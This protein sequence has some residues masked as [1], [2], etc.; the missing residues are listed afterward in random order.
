MDKKNCTLFA[1][2]SHAFDINDVFITDHLL[3]LIQDIISPTGTCIRADNRDIINWKN[4]LSA[5]YTSL[6]YIKSYRDFLVK[7]NRKGKVVVYCKECSYT[8][9][10]IQ[11]NL[12]KN[13]A[14]EGPVLKEEINKFTYEARGMSLALSK[15]KESDLIKMFDKFIEP[16]LRPE[17]LLISQSISLPDVSILSPSSD[18]ARQ[19]RAILRKRKKGLK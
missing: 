14:A 6:K 18:L 19:H 11:K 7:R 8:G 15:E 16:G 3:K 9:D 4:L 17:W 13:N 2:I 10:Y 1:R 5:K 12:V